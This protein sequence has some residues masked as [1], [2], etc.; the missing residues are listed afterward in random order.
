MYVYHR[1][2]YYKN[3][4]K[5]NVYVK[6]VNVC[7]RERKYLNIEFVYPRGTKEFKRT[8]SEMLVHSRIER[9]YWFLRE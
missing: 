1:C 4:P 7:N 5:N 2:E 3:M 6:H 9:K 8:R